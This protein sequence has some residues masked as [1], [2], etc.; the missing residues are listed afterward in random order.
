MTRAT[1]I[2]SP[3][4]R[5]SAR[6]IDGFIN[7]L[8]DRIIEEVGELAAYTPRKH[9]AA[10]AAVLVDLAEVLRGAER[11]H[12]SP[13]FAQIALIDLRVRQALA[14]TVTQLTD[15][16]P[17]SAEYLADVLEVAAEFARKGSIPMGTKRL[18]PD[19][20]KPAERRG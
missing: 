8:R 4:A 14:L 10:F 1:G 3:H 19:A 13:P 6:D 16:W 9:R 15:A 12:R 17:A 2:P 20:R 11:L 18:P 7:V 5:A